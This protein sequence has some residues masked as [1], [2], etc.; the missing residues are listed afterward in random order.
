MQNNTSNQPPKTSP[1]LYQ[2]IDG[3]N[4]NAKV[5]LAQQLGLNVDSHKQGQQQQ[6]MGQ[7]C[8]TPQMHPQNHQNMTYQ[9]HNS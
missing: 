1:D 6:A 9:G 4:Y 3:L 2:K 8:P 7:A 5:Q